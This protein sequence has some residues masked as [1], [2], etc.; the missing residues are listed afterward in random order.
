[1]NSVHTVEVIYADR[2]ACSFCILFCNTC[3]AGMTLS[4]SPSFLLSTSSSFLLF[5]ASFVCIFFFRERGTPLDAKWFDGTRQNTTFFLQKK[6]REEE[7]TAKH[8]LPSFLLSSSRRREE[9]RISSL[10]SFERSCRHRDDSFIVSDERASERR[11]ERTGG[12]GRE[13]GGEYVVNVLGE[14]N[15]FTT[16]TRD[17]ED[18]DEDDDALLDRARIF[19]ESLD[20]RVVSSR[21]RQRRGERKD[22]GW[23]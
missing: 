16:S 20:R 6:I 22:V 10:V 15:A 2:Y 8:V 11:R 9:E 21:V 14:R 19:C 12:E 13:G 23:K 4:V 1:M 5:L 7:K 18:E 17:E 3:T